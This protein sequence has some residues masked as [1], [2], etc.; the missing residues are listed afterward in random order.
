MK[1]FAATETATRGKD[2]P[3]FRRTELLL[4]R[5][6][7]LCPLCA[8]AQPVAPWQGCSMLSRAHQ[9]Q[10]GIVGPSEQLASGFDVVEAG[11]AHEIQCPG[12]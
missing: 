8:V 1:R 7:P 10:Q 5:L 11:T 4:Q 6:C 3:G 2:E 12:A 9:V